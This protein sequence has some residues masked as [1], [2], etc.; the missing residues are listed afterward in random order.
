MLTVH[1]CS[2]TGLFRHLSSPTFCC[3]KFQ[4]QVTSEAYLYPQCIQTF[5]QFLEMQE[6]IARTFFDF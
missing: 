1:K 2:D 6:K 4:K 3:L 5:I